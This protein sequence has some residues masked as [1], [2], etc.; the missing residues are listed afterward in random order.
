MAAIG[1]RI[2]RVLLEVTDL[3]VA[4]AFYAELLAT[5]GRPIRGGRHYFD[6]GDVILGLVDVSE[7]GRG[8]VPAPQNVYFAVDDLEEVHRRAMALGCL[9]A[10]A[11]HGEAG[12]EIAMRP[13]GERSFYTTD[14]SGNP[15][16]FVD[17][18]TLFAGR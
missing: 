10:D 8:A 12:G 7:T 9:S 1:P 13:W 18:N 14:P 16:C 11:V 4:V 6:C 5:P 2:F 17:A 15:V 3:D